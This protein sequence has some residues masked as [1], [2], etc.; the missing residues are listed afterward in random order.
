MF[1]FTRTD[2]QTHKLSDDTLPV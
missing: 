1:T 2:R